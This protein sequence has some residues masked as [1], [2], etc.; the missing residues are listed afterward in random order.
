MKTYQVK[1]I[2]G[3]TI[4]GEGFFVGKAVIFIRLAGCNMWDGHIETKKD[5]NCPYCDTDFVGGE[6]INVGQII[7]KVY[8]LS[9]GKIDLI[10]ISGGEPALQLEKENDPLVYTLM[11][12]G[13]TVNIETNGTIDFKTDAHVTC[14]PKQYPVVLQDINYLK[15]LYPHPNPE[16]KPENFKDMFLVEEK[17]LQPVMDKNYKE[18][19]KSCIEYIYKNPE[20]RLSLQI[21]K[22][23][24]VE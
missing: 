24:G 12:H 21:H 8:A 9:N 13:Y 11:H 3:P 16:L 15:L 7:E 17:Y 1:E 2:F 22:L 19:L 20:W 4:E 18:N 6:R 10:M 5:S 23:I 14:S